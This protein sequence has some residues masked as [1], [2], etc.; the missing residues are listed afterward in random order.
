M[1]QPGSPAQHTYKIANGRHVLTPLQVGD[2][3]Q[4]L[5]GR[6]QSDFE[7]IKL[8]TALLIAGDTVPIDVMHADGSSDHLFVTPA[9]AS[10]E[11]E[12]P[13]IGMGEYPTLK[14]PPIDA[15]D[16]EKAGEEPADFV[17][18]GKG[19]VI[20]AVNGSPVKSDQYYLLDRALQKAAGKPIEVTI[21][22]SA[23]KTHAAEFQPHFLEHFGDDPINFAGRPTR[24]SWIRACRRRSSPVMW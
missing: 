11:S 6:W 3:I 18:L 8:N 19:D 10:P 15:K 4:N 23:G 1:V 5:N 14:G 13:A 24:R 22:D 12:F 16:I 21:T 7:K 20:T 2:T 17:L 9:K